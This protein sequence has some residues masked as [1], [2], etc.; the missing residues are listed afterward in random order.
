MCI[1]I[2]GSSCQRILSLVTFPQITR[3]NAKPIS[4]HK[5]KIASEDGG[6]VTMNPVASPQF[7]NRFTIRINGLPNM[8]PTRFISGKD[9]FRG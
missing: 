4:N 9:H 3:Q 2:V 1:Y 8:Q 6:G 5:M 7:V